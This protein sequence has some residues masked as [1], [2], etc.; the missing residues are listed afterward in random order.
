MVQTK[1]GYKQTEV[2]IIPIDWEVKSLGEVVDV[3]ID[4][5]SN[6]TNPE[7]FFYYI[8]L[9]DV[10]N[11]ILRNKN[12]L[13]F[14]D[15]PSRARRRIKKN[16]ILISTVRPNLKSHLWLKEDVKDWI[17]STG[18]SVVSAKEV[19][20]G[21][22][23]YNFFFSIIENQIEALTTGSNYPAINS[24]DVKALKIPFPPTKSEQIAIATVLSD[25]DALINSLEKLIEK[26]RNIKQGTMQE[27]LK[28]KKGWE[29]KKLRD[30]CQKITTGKLDANAMVENGEY[31]FYTCAK[32]YSWI[33]HYAFDTEALLVSGNGAN[34]GYIHHYN[35]KFNAY[36][37]TYVLSEFQEDISYVKL[38][39]DKNLQNRIKTEVNA[40]NTP[41]I[42]MDTLTEMKINFPSTKEEQIRIAQILSDMD[43]EIVALEQK[44]DKYK[45]IKQGMM[46]ELLTGKTRLV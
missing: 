46:Q 22:L 29:M 27:L 1:E 7:Y 16:D 31:R 15:A 30:V 40:G 24:T 18:F 23:F 28:P 21:F 43:A 9:E 10:D 3:N 38:F 5:L 45:M 6:S 4:N 39:M 17:C 25:T 2:G 26:K 20:S 33:D 37:R 11:G 19:V 12:E 8:S 13:I 36:Q 35:G 14:K 41:Y 44:R 32:E 34:V 42:K